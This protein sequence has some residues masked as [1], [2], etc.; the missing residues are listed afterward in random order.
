MRPRPG[1]AAEPERIVREILP[2][3]G[4]APTEID[5]AHRLPQRV[6]NVNFKVGA[7]GA[8]WVLKHFPPQQNTERLRCT[9]ALELELSDAGFPVAKLQRATEGQTVIGDSTGYYSL[10]AWVQGRQISIGERERTLAEHPDLAI[11]LGRLI[12]QFHRLTVGMTVP[13]SL[14]SIEIDQMLMAPKRAAMSIRRG[15]PPR[16]FKAHLLR[17]RPRKSEFDCW[18]LDHL[19]SLYQHAERLAEVSTNGILPRLDVV[20]SH[21]DVNWENLIFDEDFEPLALLDFDNAVRIQRDIDVGLAAAVLIGPNAE[22]LQS[23]LSA[24]TD[25]ANH[26]IDSSIVTIGMQVKCARSIL[27]SIDSYLSGRV[28]DPTIIATW[29]AH[30]YECLELTSA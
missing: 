6:K 30:L 24:Y 26:D 4:F 14:P 15:R 7:G 25:A 23:F 18:I 19:P 5:G 17:F 16:V 10:H 22:R 20:V 8:D 12:G 1:N 21:H 3:F 11:D 9:H 27:W 28:A 2:R 29:C 13:D